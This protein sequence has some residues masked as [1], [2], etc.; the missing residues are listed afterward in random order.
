MKTTVI[1]II[2]LTA[3]ATLVVSCSSP[4]PIT[5][6]VIVLRDITE[7][8]L[9]KPNLDELSHIFGL[10]ENMWNG[11]S[12]YFENIT[13]VSYNPVNEAKISAQNEWLSNELERDK[14]IKDFK[15]KVNQIIINSNADTTGK[16]NSSVYLP[17]VR[18]LNQLNQS[19]S[20]R[21][22]LIVYSDLME[23]TNSISFY[24][25]KTMAVLKTNPEFMRKQFEVLQSIAELK[26]IEV[27]IIF[28]PSSTKSDSD[29]KTVS[30]FYQMLLEDK[31]AK[32]IISAN[33]NF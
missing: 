33:L 7:K 17:I 23:N 29:F 22:V 4:K 18:Q 30:E 16:N 28:Q 10:S 32:V 19:K 5:T 11:A 3:I 15:N 1:T 31:G 20:Q 21:R 24:N 12:L 6:E 26:G 9:P 14:E 27:Y 2:V 25:K 13:D 8:G